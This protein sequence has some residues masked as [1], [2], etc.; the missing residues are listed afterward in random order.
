[1]KIG[2]KLP[3]RPMPSS[4]PRDRQCV[5]KGGSGEDSADILKAIQSCNKGGRV[6]FSKGTKYTIGK[7][8]ELTSLEQ[9]DLGKLGLSQIL[10][11]MRN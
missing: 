7:A 5:V 4:S 11:R 1:V 9:M 6:V 8:Q 3:F 2:P 10:K